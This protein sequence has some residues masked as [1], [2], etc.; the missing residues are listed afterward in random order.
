MKKE[1]IHEI[2]QELKWKE[3]RLKLHSGGKWQA[4]LGLISP[5]AFVQAHE[6]Q[7]NFIGSEISSGGSDV[8]DTRDGKSERIH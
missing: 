8:L 4:E 1:S 7:L 2:S 3:Q 5:Q 6:L